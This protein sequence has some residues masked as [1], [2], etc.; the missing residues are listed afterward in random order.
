MA[1]YNGEHYIKEQLDSLLRQTYTNWK[2]MIRDDG[3]ADNTIAIA[4]GY[5]HRHTNISLQINHTSIKGA[6][7]NFAALYDMAAKSND[8]RYIMFC[9]Q[10]DIW[11]PEKIEKTLAT[12]QEAEIQYPTVPIMVY[13]NLELM[14]SSGGFLDEQIRLM[15]RMDFNHTIAQNYAFG[16]TMM[17]NKPLITAIDH[18]PTEAQNHDYWISLTATALGRAVYIS[19]K[20]IRYRQHELNVT[21]QGAGFKKRIVRFT[22]GFKRQ[23]TAFRSQITMLEKF[24]HIFDGKLTDDKKLMLESYLKA[25]RTG[26]LA[27]LRVMKKHKIYKL[28]LM[29]NIGLLYTVMLFY[30]KLNP[31]MGDEREL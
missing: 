30:K 21:A 6:R 19:E 28:G 23:L 20:L 17:I 14:T 26:R 31:G 5:T 22:T 18:I 4:T 16:C 2:L 15:P 8:T 10:D 3:S 24:L 13:G 12:M 7:S 11:L 25:Y 29:Q 9:D 27:L 1:T